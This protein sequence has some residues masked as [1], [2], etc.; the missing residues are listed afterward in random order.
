MSNQPEKYRVI[1][2]I[3]KLIIPVCLGLLAWSTSDSANKIAQSNLS[4]T[5]AQNDLNRRLSEVNSNRE[6]TQ[7]DAQLIDLFGKYYFGGKPEQ[8]KFALR[9]IK[10]VS[11]GELQ[12][13]IAEAVATDP[14]LNNTSAGQV[15]RQQAS[16]IVNNAVQ[17]EDWMASPPSEGWCFQK[18]NGEDSSND[19]Y[20]VRCLRLKDQCEQ[21]RKKTHH[22][23][24]SCQLVQKLNET[25]WNPGTGGLLDAWYKYSTKQFQVPFP[26][27][28]KKSV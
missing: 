6:G 14:K 9:I 16:Q 4:L 19:R 20:L 1:Q 10:E 5:A 15:I 18:D 11:S 12:R 25:N 17:R 27:D 26:T 3:E 23:K 13:A 22:L 24:T 7:L 21:L 8:Q 2:I 28:F